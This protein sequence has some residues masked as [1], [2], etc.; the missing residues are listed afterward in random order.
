[1]LRWIAQDPRQRQVTASS[2][3]RDGSSWPAQVSILLPE[4]FPMTVTVQPVPMLTD[5]YAWLLRDTST[6]ALCLVDPPDARAA[7]AAIDAAIGEG[8]GELHSILLTH[9]HPD[10]TAGA[11]EVRAHYGCRIIGASQDAHRLPRLDQGVSEG[12]TVTFGSASAQVID[13][14][15]HTRG[16]I[17]FFFPEGSVLLCGDTLFSLGCG[18]L[19]EG[20]PEEMFASLHKLAALPGD[21]LVCCGHEYTESNARFAVTI[22]PDNAALLKRAGEVRALRQAGKPTVPSRLADELAQNP[23]LRAKDAAELGRIRS[24]KDR[25]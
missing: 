2:L 14:P 25:F 4:V 6:G 3:Q 12:D 9:H 21:A 8:G 5:N 19:L 20:T 13:T 15:G 7:I 24:A 16:H 18:R 22:E 11:D 23:F 10:H 1:M 17:A